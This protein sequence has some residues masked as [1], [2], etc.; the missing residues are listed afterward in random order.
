ML[1]WPNGKNDR[2][3]MMNDLFD[4]EIAVNAGFFAPAGLDLGSE[5]PEEI[6]LA[7]VSEV[8]RVF[9]AASGESLRERK[10]SIHAPVRSAVLA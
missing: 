9:A 3:Q 5:M 6:A 1:I 2:N 4:R 7:I 8:Q 10:M